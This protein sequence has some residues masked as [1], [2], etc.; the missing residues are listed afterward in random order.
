MNH[1]EQRYP[2]AETVSGP[3]VMVTATPPA[4]AGLPIVLNT[5]GGAYASDGLAA[6]LTTAECVRHAK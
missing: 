1:Y 4:C 3:L 5:V 2:L 6:Y